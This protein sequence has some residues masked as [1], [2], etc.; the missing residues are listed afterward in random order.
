MLNSNDIGLGIP[1]PSNEERDYAR[2]NEHA[3]T[4]YPAV[5]PLCRQPGKNEEQGAKKCLSDHKMT[6][7]ITVSDATS[8]HDNAEAARQR[9][10]M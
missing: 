7:Q 1:H 5:S 10:I 9:P 4:P 3:T 6:C 2:Q 8:R